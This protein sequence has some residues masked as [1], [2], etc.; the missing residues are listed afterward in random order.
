M[1]SP[2]LKYLLLI[3]FLGY[4]GSITL[5]SHTHQIEGAV[6]A[7]SHPYKTANHQHSSGEFAVISTSPIFNI[8]FHRIFLL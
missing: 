7:H 5:F 8:H 2:I 6:K 3:L 1:R 4:F